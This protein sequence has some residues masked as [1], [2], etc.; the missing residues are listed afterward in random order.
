[1][2]SHTVLP[3]RYGTVASD[4]AEILEIIEERREIIKSLF[5]KVRGKV[6]LGIKV[7]WNPEP[8]K[9]QVKRDDCEIGQ[10]RAKMRK[11]Q[12]L[13]KNERAK[14]R[15]YLMEKLYDELVQRKV[16]IDGE[17]FISN[18]LAKL[19]SL[20]FDKVFAKFTTERLLLSAS[21]LVTKDKVADFELLVQQLIK[22][23]QQLSFLLTGPWPPYNFTKIQLKELGE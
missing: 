13:S 22:Q 20:S 3:M 14:G 16:K 5:D 17:K 11:L 6:E 8:I 15:L 21:F 18:I 2:S 23:H 19:S 4:K 12:A 7:L 10:L 9:E 1:M